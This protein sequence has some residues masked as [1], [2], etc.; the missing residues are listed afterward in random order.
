MTQHHCLRRWITLQPR[1]RTKW[2]KVYRWPQLQ[3]SVGCRSSISWGSA[4]RGSL[5]YNQLFTQ[6]EK[7]KTQHRW[8]TT[9]LLNWSNYT[10]QR[11]NHAFDQERERESDYFSVIQCVWGWRSVAA[12]LH[13]MTLNESTDESSIGTGL[14]SL[15]LHTASDCCYY[16]R[17]TF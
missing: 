6:L 12:E 17:Q 8:I 2:S 9:F 1:N 15:Q 11:C 3:W 7:Q 4:F 10:K 14:L 13:L 5:D 16:T